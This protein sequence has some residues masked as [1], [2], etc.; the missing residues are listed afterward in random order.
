MGTRLKPGRARLIGVLALLALIGLPLALGGHHHASLDPG[1]DCATCVVVHH[2]PAQG[3]APVAL[4]VPLVSR[5]LAAPAGL[6]S[7]A[8]IWRPAPSSRGPPAPFA[9]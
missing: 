1:R 3:A 4:P 9:A 8:S 6:P 5:P 7:L 2:S